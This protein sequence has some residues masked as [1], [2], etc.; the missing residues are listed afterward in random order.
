M[1]QVSR[2]LDAFLDRSAWTQDN[3]SGQGHERGINLG[4]D[5]VRF[6]APVLSG[7]DIRAVFHLKDMQESK[8]GQ[9]KQLLGVSVELKGQ[10]KPALLADW[11]ILSRL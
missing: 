1:V 2:A 10:D 6:M 9:V 4:F 11:I 3:P 7:S 5:R 8:P